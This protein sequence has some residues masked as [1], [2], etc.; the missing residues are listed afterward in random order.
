MVCTA[1]CAGH[2][3][4]NLV[5]PCI[6]QTL[7]SAVA[8]TFLKNTRPAN[9]NSGIALTENMCLHERKVACEI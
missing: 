7:E 3:R 4:T 1:E 8:S 2:W 9:S 5:H 6:V